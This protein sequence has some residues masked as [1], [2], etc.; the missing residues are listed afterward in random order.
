MHFPVLGIKHYGNH[1]RN[2]W[3]IPVLVDIL[4]SPIHKKKK[5]KLKT[6][7]FITVIYGTHNIPVR[8]R[9]LFTG[10]ITQRPT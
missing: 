7:L 2:A 10:L 5:R 8:D 6:G 4:S 3:V 1:N 9:I